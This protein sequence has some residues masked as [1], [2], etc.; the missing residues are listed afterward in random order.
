M[1]KTAFLTAAAMLCTLLLVSTADAQT[2]DQARALHAE[3]RFVEAAEL[4]A[5]LKTSEGYALA[6]QALA[7]QGYVFAGDEDKQGLFQRA[8]ELADEA[9]RLDPANP[10]AHIQL[11][12][13][14]GRYAQTVGF[15]QAVAGGYATKVR[16]SVEEALR[17]DPDKAAGHLSL[18]TWHAEIVHAA[19]GMARFLYGATEKK[20]RGHYA[21]ALELMP[22]AKV[23]CVEYA[24]GLLLL[25]EEGNRDEARR[26]L[27]RAVRKP[28]KDAVDRFYHKLA[29]ARLAALNGG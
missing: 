6:A 23:V 13:A 4:G 22:D 1:T 29:V 16:E 14:R 9:V 17:L 12:H 10:E 3:G 27:E 11:A 15:L 19:G 28:S 24:Y 5:A 20:A 26:L 25:D 21:R 8:V 2:V 18:A 7:M